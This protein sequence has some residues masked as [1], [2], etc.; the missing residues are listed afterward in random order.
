[1]L[2]WGSQWVGRRPPIKARVIFFQ[3]SHSFGANGGGEQRG[4]GLPI[5]QSLAQKAPGAA[6]GGVGGCPRPP[7]ALPTPAALASQSQGEAQVGNRLVPMG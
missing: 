4:T 7:L 2:L 1:M 3:C 5:A 6:V